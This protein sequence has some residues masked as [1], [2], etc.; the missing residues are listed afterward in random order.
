MTKLTAR[1]IATLRMVA[2]GE[3]RNAGFGNSNVDNRS[4]N[5]L[6][7]RGFV[8]FDRTVE[9]GAALTMDGRALARSLDLL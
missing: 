8:R 2:T 9:G 1:Q 5:S 4:F 3:I 6:L 7:D